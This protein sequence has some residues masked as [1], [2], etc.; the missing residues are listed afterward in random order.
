M[1]DG[2]PPDVLAAVAENFG[3]GSVCALA[4]VC[5]DLRASLKLARPLIVLRCDRL[6]RAVQLE[7]AS[8]WRLRSLTLVGCADDEA[9]PAARRVVHGLVCVLELLA[10]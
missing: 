4:A 6:D 7:A 8:L 9:W 5:A 1:I 3:D 2:L 10:W